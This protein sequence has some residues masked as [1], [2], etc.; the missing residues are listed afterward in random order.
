M[1]SR[2]L[3]PNC[4]WTSEVPI[5][6]VAGCLA[7]WHVF[8]K[9]YDVWQGIFRDRPPVD[10]DPRTEEGMTIAMAMEVLDAL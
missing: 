8:E 2:C 9:H 6:S 10:P 1:A 5:K 3:V 4:D 7:T